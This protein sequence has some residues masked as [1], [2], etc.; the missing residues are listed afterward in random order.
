[1]KNLVHIALSDTGW[2]LE[3]LAREVEQRMPEVSFGLEE[4]RRAPIQYYITY[5]RRVQRVS[6]VEV[7]LFTHLEQDA[8]AAAR[9]FAAARD[10]DAAVSMSRATAGILEQAGIASELIMPGVDLDR[11]RPRLK[12]AV[13]GRTYHTGRKGEALVQAVMDIP[14]IDWHFTGP[15]WPGPAEPVSDDELPELYRSADY[16]LVP[17]HNE[18]GPMCVLEALACGTPVI[19]SQVGWVPDFP[20]IA[21]DKGDASS[22]RRVLLDLLEKKRRLAA[23]VQDMTWDHWAEGHS[24]LFHRLARERGLQAAPVSVTAPERKLRSVALVTH[25][26]ESSVLGGPTVRVPRTAAALKRLGLTAEA[27]GFPAARA[28]EHQLVHGFNFWPPRS[29]AKMARLLARE[30]KPLVFSPILLDLGEFGL[31]HTALSDA[32]LT[33]DSAEAGLAAYAA[34]RE[35]W[36]AG[37][38][39]AAANKEPE[40]GFLD[41]LREVA[42]RSSAFIFLSEHEQALAARLSPRLPPLQRIV[43]N[44]VDAAAFADADPTLFR[45]AHGLQDYVLC[46]GRVERRKNQLLLALAARELGVPLVLVG[47]AGESDY[48]EWLKR[49]A[50]TDILHVERLEP[51]SPMLRSAMAGARVFALPSWAEGAPLAALE[52]AAAGA[53]LVLSDRS[54][55]REYFGDRARYCDPASMES[56]RDAIASAWDKPRSKDE[57]REQQAHVAEAFSWERYAEATRDVYADVLA[58]HQQRVPVAAAKPADE[59]VATPVVFDLTTTRHNRSTRSGIV[60][61]EGALAQELALRPDTDLHF[62]VWHDSNHGYLEIPREVVLNGLLHTYIDSSEPE[63]IAVRSLPKGAHLVI[64][65]SSWMQ[66]GQYAE[67]VAELAALHGLR[68]SVMMHDFTPVLFPYWYPPGYAAPFESHMSTLLRSAER[69]LVYSD[70]S[71]R[72]LALV[73]RDLGIPVPS[74]AK[75]RLAD[76]I[77]SFASAPSKLAEGP[78]ERWSRTPF[79]LAVGGIHARKN[80]GLLIDVWRQ[81]ARDMADGCPHLLIV[82]GVSWNGAEQARHIR[83]DKRLARVVHILD[84]ID[85]AGLDSLYR[86]CLFSVYPSLYE[87]W[88]LPVAESMAYGKLCLAANTSSVPEVAPGLAVL[89]DPTDRQ[90][91]ITA[92]RHYAGSASAR[93][94]VEERIRSSYQPTTWAA[95]AAMLLAAL[96]EPA[97]ALQRFEY[98]L[99]D[100]VPLNKAAGPCVY[101]LSGWHPR[102]DWGSWA[103]RPQARLRVQLTCRPEEDLVLSAVA[104]VFARPGSSKTVQVAVNGQRVAVWSFFSPAGQKP[105]SKPDTVCMARVP[106]A[107]CPDDGV[108]DIEFQ[109][110]QLEPIRAVHPNSADV[111]S[112]GIGLSAFSVQRASRAVDFPASIQHWPPLSAMLR[113]DDLQRTAVRPPMPV[114]RWFFPESL[115]TSVPTIPE[116]HGGRPAVS[117]GSWV[118]LRGGLS[119][120]ALGQDLHVDALVRAA[121]PGG[122]RMPLT[123][124]VDNR[125]VGIWSIDGTNAVRLTMRVPAAMLGQR[126]PL[127]LA[128]FA[129]HIPDQPRAATPGPLADGSFELLKLRLRQGEE[130]APQRARLLPGEPLLVSAD[131]LPGLLKDGV[132]D[133]GWQQVE[134]DGI[135]SLGNEGRLHLQVPAS[136]GCLAVLDVSWLAGTTEDDAVVVACADATM[137]V[138]IDAPSP[139]VLRA[140]IPVPLPEGEAGDWLDADLRLGRLVLPEPGTPANLNDPRL[141]GLRL[142]GVELARLRPIDLGIRLD[143]Q[144]LAESSQGL[145]DGWHDADEFQGEIVC[146]SRVAQAGLLLRLAAGWLERPRNLRLRLLPLP[147]HEEPFVMRVRINGR[148]AL[149]A[150]LLDF[151]LQTVD[152]P[153]DADWIGSAGLLMITIEAPLRS[154]AELGFGTDERVVGVALASVE[155]L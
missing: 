112:L 47:H 29:S 84:D 63:A 76:E 94:A 60:R 134:A 125:P 68:L 32:F 148:V 85:D 64:V 80:Y 6:P 20:H 10:C 52:A 136:D 73:S 155:V 7:M 33:A 91:W 67:N 114:N 121:P 89:L 108:L 78:L 144:E 15:G 31:W 88:G 87:G 150:S 59:A 151:A 18:G 1:M 137:R 101:R 105:G 153:L 43:H 120:L 103:S 27:M 79:V 39:V 54:S 19:G 95:S 22:L 106:A 107:L 146:W 8:N 56:I 104:R 82:G 110:P 57:R 49:E 42:E 14:D 35:R 123:L 51:V 132:L 129:P 38:A 77:G 86:R 83:E 5:S 3:R 119:G 36:H 109:T 23:S 48:A 98:T 53:N 26:L 141:L 140:K 21:F 50:G 102:E 96:A 113:G 152:V 25:G 61:V 145:L 4:D 142:H 111:R 40:P 100:L 12:I 46:V 74:S 90:A 149:D 65:G 147:A 55:E 44:P 118:R 62:V 115:T 128:F 66:N 97:Q 16:V 71:R 127:E 37:G 138:A 34:A 92:V 99:G 41:A 75:L 17:A 69:V 72:D 135:W 93:E 13:V 131:T 30:D 58:T 117:Q 45:K 2:I 81:L 122:G 116:A 28:Y 24:R 133:A 143:L 124:M 130:A 11:F 126:D 9:F 154:P 139:V 70:N